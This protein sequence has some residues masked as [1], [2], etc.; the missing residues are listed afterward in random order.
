MPRT[1]ISGEP[2]TTWTNDTGKVKY[3]FFATF[4]NTCGMC[5]QYHLKIS[6]RWPIPLHFGCHCGQV[7]IK[8]DA[9]AQNP[10]CD[11]RELLDKM[12]QAEKTAAIGA[13]NYKLL[14][15]GLATWD[16]IVTPHRVRD[17]REVVAKKHLSVEQ[18]VKHGVKR[19][20]AEQAYSAV[21]TTEHQHIER[22]RQELLQ[23]ITGAGLSQE[24]LVK[25]L[26]KG[27]AARVSFA[28]G[29]MV[30]TGPN[31]FAPAWGGGPIPGTGMSHAAELATLI[32][33]WRPPGK[34]TPTP[35]PPPPS[36]APVPDLAPYPLPEIP[37]GVPYSVPIGQ[38]IGKPRDTGELTTEPAPPAPAPLDQ[39]LHSNP[40]IARA[41]QIG[42]NAGVKTLV[43]GDRA[44]AEK[45]W[46]AKI[47]EVGAQYH[48]GSD[49]ILINAHSKYWEQAQI[50]AAHKSGWLAT[51]GQD[52]II[53]H[54]LGHRAHR[55]AVGVKRFGEL[56]KSAIPGGVM[57]ERIKTEV[58]RYA[59]KKRSEFVAEVYAGLKARQ[60][61]SAKV[62]DY[63]R[64]QGGVLP[65]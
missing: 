13:S 35:K 43:I 8:P 55:Q 48:P 27:I 56:N 53:T 42:S 62:M 33:A 46:G 21:H 12:P 26:S 24:N 57:K 49:L 6:E 10:F 39:P 18:M 9:K 16:D 54:E 19:I 51:N 25:E 64:L 1:I 28:A 2:G 47:D 41:Q 37:A 4:T 11:Y 36:A 44:Q 30:S 29:P 50:D 31:T 20:F 58:S 17:F 63:Y 3:Q 65:R 34:P 14:K 22:Q 45:V 60:K 40:M 5:L 23:K 61:Y 59:A 32:S 7:S 52:H 38:S 15:S